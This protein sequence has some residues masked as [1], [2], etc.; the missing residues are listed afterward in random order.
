MKEN[1]ILVNTIRGWNANEDAVRV[2]NELEIP[3]N[4]FSKVMNKIVVE[5]YNKSKEEVIQV[6]VFRPKKVILN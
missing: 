3:K 6:P 1:T 5:W 2:L 4:Q